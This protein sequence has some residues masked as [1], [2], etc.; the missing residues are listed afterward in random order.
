MVQY[1]VLKSTNIFTGTQREFLNGYVVIEGQTIEGVYSLDQLPESIKQEGKLIDCETHTI[2]PGFIEAHAHVQ[3]SALLFNGLIQ[4][5]NGESEAECVQQLSQQAATAARINGWLV[6]KGWYLPNWESQQLPTKASLD[7]AFSSYPVMLIS[8]DLHTIWL[9]SLGLKALKSFLE[10][11]P[12]DVIKHSGEPSGVIKEKTAMS[13]MNQVLT[14]PVTRREEIYGSYLTHLVSQGYTSV[15]DLALLPAE[16]TVDCDDQIYPEVYQLLEEQGRLPVRA[17]L[18]PFFDLEGQRVKRL[19][20]QLKSSLV[21]IAGGKQF[22]DG[23][24]S[25][26]TAWLK[27]NYEKETHAGSPVL[28][29]EILRQMIN[30]A[31]KDQIPLRIHCIGDQASSLAIQYFLDAQQEHGPLLNGHHAL[32]HLERIEK[33]DMQP[34]KE[35]HLVASVQPS[36]PLMDYQKAFNDI[37]ER[38]NY[39]WP[40]KD[41]AKQG[42]PLAFG[43]DSPV[44]QE[45]SPF[46]N[47]Y[48]AMTR[49]TKAG[50]PEG[51]WQPEQQLE[52]YE[53]LLAHTRDAAKSC[54]TQAQI[55]TLAAGKSADLVI[56]EGDLWAC[57]VNELHQKSVLATI[58]NGQL[59]YQKEEGSTYVK[60]TGHF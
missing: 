59:N 40:I 35:A 1:H 4:N 8:D 57:P 33:Q 16:N 38:S 6:A 31:Q 27:E 36:H 9:N 14:L 29:P 24:I 39:M 51:G 48:Y 18:F 53:A 3:L 17:F 22:F 21:S 10:L 42:V 11:K 43:S 20:Q 49:Q 46:D 44:V 28:E 23:V 34:L 5:V 12:E 60:R 26:H 55:G 30:Q 19:R 45:V 58:V 37:G 7:A 54:G 13:C 50:E 56:I 15:C 25:S 2:A 41:L 52:L 47:F 32:E